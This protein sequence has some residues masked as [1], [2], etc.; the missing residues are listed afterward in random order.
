MPF[1]IDSIL[2]DIS[3]KPN[4]AGKYQIA[5]KL[6]EWRNGVQIGYVKRD[7]E[8]KV[9]Q[10]TN[11]PNQVFC[12]MYIAAASS[13]FWYQGS[14]TPTWYLTV[15]QLLTLHFNA[16][17]TITHICPNIDRYGSASVN[18]SAWSLNYGSFDWYDSYFYFPASSA[19]V[20]N[21][22]YLITFR[23][24]NANTFYID[25]TFRIFVSPHITGINEISNNTNSVYLK[26][27]DLLGR[28]IDPNL[29]GFRI[30]VYSD[31][32]TKKVFR[33]E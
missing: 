27:I 9:L 25:Y 23:V 1:H 20:S 24:N 14:P 12:Q 11:V 30:D 19:T 16:F 15:S 2:G 13:S 6:I 8:V 7:M 5:V 33:G 32:K 31:G 22:P 21:N 3:F 18:T 10:N 4:V 28:E 29:P 26:S 17:D